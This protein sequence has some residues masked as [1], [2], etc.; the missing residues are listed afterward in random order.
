MATEDARRGSVR[1]DVVLQ[2]QYRS[3]GHM[4]VNYCTNLSRGGL[5]IPAQRPLPAGSTLT[6]ELSVPGDAAPTHIEATVRWVR[7]FD[8]PEGPAGMGLSFV[9]ADSRLGDRIDN[10]VTDFQPLSVFIVGRHDGVREYVA[11][12]VR[13]LVTCETKEFDSPIGLVDIVG[14]ADL[15]IVDANTVPDET[16]AFLRALESLERPPPRVALCD[17]AASERR[18]TLAPLARVVESPVETEALRE[19]VLDSLSQV[20]TRSKP[21]A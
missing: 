9:D 20:F 21:P 1:A 18:E 11:A 6:L 8:A 13:T 2:L 7:Q 17:A 4:L 15:V 5:F 10:L 19:V 12:Q 16:L 14:Q 3:A